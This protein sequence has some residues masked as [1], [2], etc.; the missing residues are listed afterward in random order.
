MSRSKGRGETNIECRW[1]A[2]V[3]IIGGYWPLALIDSKKWGFYAAGCQSCTCTITLIKHCIREEEEVKAV[4]AAGV[5]A[6][7]THALVVRKS[8]KQKCLSTYALRL[9]LIISFIFD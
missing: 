6:A 2:S 4:F 5:S 3:L 1:E 9:Q 8:R 7:D